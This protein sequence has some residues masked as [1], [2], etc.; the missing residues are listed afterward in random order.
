MSTLVTITLSLYFLLLLLFRVGWNRSLRAKHFAASIHQISV[1]IPFRNE[2]QNL[3]QLVESLKKIDYPINRYEVIL[4]DDHSTDHSLS[5]ARDLTSELENINILW[6]DERNEGKK[7]ALTRGIENAKGDIVVTT[8]ADCEVPS[9]WLKELNNAFGEQHHQL[10]F[11]AVTLKG[12]NSFFSRLQAMEFLSLIGSA[13]A[14]MGFGWFTMCNGANMAFRKEAFQKVK[15]YEG[16]ENVPSGDDEFLARKI[17][18]A[19]P[20]SVAFLNKEEGVVVT[21]AQPSLK[22]FISQRIRWAGKWRYN[23]SL[24]TKLLAVFIAW[25]QILWML[26]M[27]SIPF[28]WLPLDLSIALILTKLVF[29]L[30]VLFPVHRFT[31]VN[32]DSFAFL[33]LQFVYPLYVLSIGLASMV[34]GYRWK[35]RSLIHKM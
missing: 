1:V 26:T 20:G 24:T 28:N 12:S 19:F 13:V 32:W 4:V 3:N 35:G 22:D 6:L 31:R 16:N 2:E 9:G 25:V 14:T 11:G 15:G 17:L 21:P 30:L 10:V 33:T 8:D 5:K 23:Q 27:L 29:E 34:S 7:R 18:K